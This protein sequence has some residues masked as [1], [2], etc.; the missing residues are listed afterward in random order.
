MDSGIVFVARE[1]FD[2]Y[3]GHFYQADVTINGGARGAVPTDAN[4][5][6]VNFGD[7]PDPDQ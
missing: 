6:V 4:E 2:A 5:L 1:R 7:P 3:R